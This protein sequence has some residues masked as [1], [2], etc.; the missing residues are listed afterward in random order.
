M[1][2][3]KKKKKKSVLFFSPSFCQAF[4]TAE[5]NVRNLVI[6]ISIKCT[7]RNN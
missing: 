3:A 1:Q 6:N 2:I 5:K 7:Q 4:Y